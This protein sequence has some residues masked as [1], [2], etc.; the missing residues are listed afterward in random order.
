MLKNANPSEQPKKQI[1]IKPVA[2]KHDYFIVLCGLQR[3]SHQIGMGMQ[4]IM[5][6]HWKY[7]VFFIMCLEFCSGLEKSTFGAKSDF[8]I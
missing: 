7:F 4:S 3:C 6:S 5:A 1:K 2:I 8:E